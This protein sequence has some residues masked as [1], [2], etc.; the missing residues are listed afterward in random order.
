MKYYKGF[1][2]LIIGLQL[3]ASHGHGQSTGY[4]FYKYYSSQ[5]YQGGIQNWKITQSQAGLLY[6]ANNFGLLEFDGTNWN[7][8][9]LESGTKCRDVYVDSNGKIYIAAQGDFG[10]Y[11]PDQ[12]GKL[13]FVSLADSIPDENRNF[14]E[15]WRVFKK[16]DQILFCTF[17]DIFIYNLSGRLVNIVKPETDPDNFFL[18]NNKLFLNQ[19][20]KGLSVMEDELVRPTSYGDYFSKMTISGIIELD[21]DQLLIS[22]LKNGVY[23]KTGGHIDVWN[24][25]SQATF[26]NSNINKMKRLRSGNIAIGTQNDGL[27]VLN[28]KGEIQLHLN[29]GK[30]IENR[31]VLSLHEDI[32][33]NLW[34]GHNNGISSVAL[35]SPFEHVNE[36][37]GLPGTG[38]DALLINDTLFLGTN[39]GLYYKN[40]NHKNHLFEEVKNTIG[41]VYTVQNI[42]NEVILGHHAGTFR[43][44]N[45]TAQII[46]EIPGTW[47][48]LDLRKYPNYVIQGNYKGLSL[49]KKTDK[50]IELL[51]E[52][53]GFEESSRV[54]EEDENGNIWMTHGYK[55]VYK[56]KLA[57]DLESVSA[58]YY[59]IEEG[60]PSKVLINVWRLNNTVIFS[61]EDG[62]YEYDQMKDRFVKSSFL[63]DHFPAE[64]QFVSFA[65][66]A[67]GNIYFVSMKE[68]G[69]L[70]KSTNGKYRK[71]TSVFNQLK[72]ALNDDLHKIIT[73][74]AN[75][76]LFAAKEGFVQFDNTIQKLQDINFDVIF[77]KV[78]ISNSKD[79][80]I[81]YGRQMK[82]DAV[83]FKQLNQE[84]EIP[85]KENSIRLEYSAPYMNGQ[86]QNEYQYWLKNN[87]TGFSDWSVRTA[88]EYTNLKEGNYI[89]QVRARNVYGQL[90]NVATFEFTILPPWFRTTWAYS[91]YVITGLVSS[92]LIFLFI[93]LRYKK[94]TEIITEEKE[95][96][97]TR[98]DSEL[99]T[100][101]EQLEHLKN[102]KLK[103]EIKLKNKELA[104]STMHLINKNSFINSIKSNLNTI[105][106]RSKNQEVKHEISRVVHNID[107]NISADDDWEHFSIHFD[108]VHGDFIKR[109]K[110]D[111]PNLSPQ[112]I[113]LSAYLRMNLSTKE[114][115]HLLNISV[116]GVE[117]ARYRLRKKLELE[118]AD[119]LQEF[120]LKY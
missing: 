95:K 87:E 6:V 120:I 17:D 45:G 16:N 81:T 67:L 46:S 77:T 99:K 55:G 37:T 65:E 88:K 85:Y 56:I 70:E 82:G 104:T 31:T 119:N 116:R 5:D 110:N 3:L 12:K 24:K 76:V 42:N 79:S 9:S 11:I 80:I 91:L 117:I 75:K 73:L 32:Q 64:T 115:A 69:V 35:N 48:F 7:K 53:K 54:M 108:Q 98:I 74:D 4:P 49:F 43:I 61:T 21:N 39:N 14:D 101:E 96:E 105:S 68:T 25:L 107:K 28:V 63:S 59:G 8:Y 60:L 30:G 113:K 1:L 103:S 100:S 97:I 93:E 27:Y 22:T 41:Q 52:L 15:A 102:E 29:K 66:D 40:I 112:E 92:I 118:R 72:N 36:Q 47:T 23:L 33:G 13:T 18:V 78:G 106:K 51:H 20:G 38:Y 57:D 89:F 90:S 71:H 83:S 114:I 111:Y 2:L 62:L 34:L 94:K 26:K 50:G 58:E 19:A 44:R 10:Y 84:I 109:W 86:F